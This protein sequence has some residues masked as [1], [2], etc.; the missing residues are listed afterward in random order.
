MIATLADAAVPHPPSIL[1]RTGAAEPLPDW[2]DSG[3]WIKRGDVH[4]MQAGDVVFCAN[5]R[6]VPAVLSAFR[7]RDIAE[8]II[9]RHVPGPVIKFYAVR[10]SFFTWFAPRELHL[11]L[12]PDTAA[13]LRDL[14]ERGA[15]ALGLEIF[16]GDCVHQ[17]NGEPVLIDLN[18][19]PSYGRC[20][21]EAAHAIASYVATPNG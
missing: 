8:V 11:E 20:R 18:D 21:S 19:W 1:M 2:I 12:T 10:A 6:A 17:G 16:G 7:R 3:A 9:Q 13:A 14:A 15:A 5:A 4:A